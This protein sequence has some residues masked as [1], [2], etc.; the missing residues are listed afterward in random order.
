MQIINEFYITG[1]G[2]GAVISK[3]FGAL[4]SIVL[5]CVNKVKIIVSCYASVPTPTRNQ[6]FCLLVS[7]LG[8]DSHW[9]G[10]VGFYQLDGI[11]H[12][13]VLKKCHFE[14]FL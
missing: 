13:L 6:G 12:K 11:W 7:E 9:F 14:Y 4:R 5:Q 3:K 8:I 2:V 10:R 1:A